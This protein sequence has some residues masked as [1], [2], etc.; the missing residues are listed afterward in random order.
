MDI[1]NGITI[2]C[3]LNGKECFNLVIINCQLPPGPPASRFS[4]CSYECSNLRFAFDCLRGEVKK[5]GSFGWY[6]PHEG[7]RGLATTLS[8]KQPVFDFAFK[9]F[10]TCKNTIK[11]LKRLLPYL[12]VF[13]DRLS[14]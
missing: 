6:V 11:L 5:S 14:G 1:I 9:A 4:S 12:G 7:G 10:K 2:T 13:N 3:V 8:K